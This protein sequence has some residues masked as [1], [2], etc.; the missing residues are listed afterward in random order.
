MKKIMKKRVVALIVLTMISCVTT[1]SPINKAPKAPDL[2]VSQESIK[3]SAKEISDVSE[4]VNNV[5]TDVD[6]QATS[7]E[8]KDSEGVMKPEVNELRTDAQLLRQYK[9]KLD[10]TV[11]KLKATEGQLIVATQ[12]VQVLEDT[13]DALV[14]ENGDLIE[15]NT[16]LKSEVKAALRAKLTYCVMLGIVM[17]A[18]CGFMFVNGKAGAIGVGVVGIIIVVVSLAISY[19][20]VQL[21]IIGVVGMIVT[22]GIGGY[23]A[24]RKRKKETIIKE[25]DDLIKKQGTAIKEVTATVEHLKPHIPKTQIRTLFGDLITDGE[26][27]IIQT[28]PT[29]EL[30]FEARKEIS[31]KTKPTVPDNSMAA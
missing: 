28:D 21:A 6:K 17:I 18:I 20:T 13:N 3:K 30:I 27:G 24:F 11:T 5:A 22:L 9:I 15:E 31:E 1:E 19:F 16:D 29:K 2:S 10:E 23:V 8:G 12:Q 14:T 26:V 25:Q 7:I 4:G